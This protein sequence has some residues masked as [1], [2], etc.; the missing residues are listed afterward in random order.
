MY[1]R[2]YQDK[3]EQSL[4]AIANSYMGLLF[5]EDLPERIKAFLGCER[6]FP[7]ISADET[8]G[9]FYI[10]GKKDG[11]S[12]NLETTQILQL[13]GKTVRD[14]DRAINQYRTNTLSTNSEFTRSK[15]LNRQLQ[16]TVEMRE[17]PRSEKLYSDPF[18]ITDS[19]IQHISFHNEKYFFQVYG[20][21]KEHEVVS[22]LRESLLGR[23]VMVGFN[24]QDQK[25]VP[26]THPLIP[27]FIHLRA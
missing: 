5:P 25:G 9:L 27:L 24:R 18:I 20:P 3:L 17:R 14:F 23:M 13:C 12:S 2:V 10:F 1:K 11:I 4:T 19:L 21:L 22:D 26:F 16:I 15:Y 8:I 7:Y 6:D